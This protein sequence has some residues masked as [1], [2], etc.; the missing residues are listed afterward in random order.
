MK[1]EGLRKNVEA[2]LRFSQL[3]VVGAPS[4]LP[5]GVLQLFDNAVGFPRGSTNGFNS[6]FEGFY[7]N[8]GFRAEKQVKIAVFGLFLT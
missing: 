7:R 5:Q 6:K 4:F 2:F 1:W 8:D 3:V